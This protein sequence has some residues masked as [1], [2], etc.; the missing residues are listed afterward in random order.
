M[1]CGFLIADR[2]YDID[3]FRQTLI[4]KKILSVISRQKS[5]SVQIIYDK[6]IYRERNAV[7]QFFGRIKECRRIS[8]RYDK[9]AVM[10]RESLIFQS[11]LL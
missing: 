7:E 5:R 9:T 4:K 8:T 3:A 1:K 11:I 10:F 2:G 6:Y